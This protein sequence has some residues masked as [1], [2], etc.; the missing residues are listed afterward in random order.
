MAAGNMAKPYGINSEGLRRRG[1]GNETIARIKRAYRTLYRA[2][3]SLDEA[4]RELAAQAADCPEVAA[5]VDFLA[6][7]R[8]GFIR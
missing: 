2:G 6:R 8:R 7:S 4:K 3:L 1:F 5:L